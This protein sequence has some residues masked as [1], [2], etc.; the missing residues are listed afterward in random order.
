MEKVLHFTNIG[1]TNRFIQKFNINFR[2]LNCTEK[3]AGESDD[4]DD[5]KQADEIAITVVDD[6]PESTVP[7][8]ALVAK[9]EK[10]TSKSSKST[11]I[12]ASKL[13]R[14]KLGTGTGPELAGVE[15]G[16][17]KTGAKAKPTRQQSSQNQSRQ[18]RDSF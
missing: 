8:V 6:K 13:R 7:P 18:L 2:K 12:E 17:G 16:A 14:R 10:S 15:S 3:K 1:R 11:K 4:A 5:H 9:V